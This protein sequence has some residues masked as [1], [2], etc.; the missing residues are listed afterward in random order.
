MSKNLVA[1]RVKQSWLKR[2]QSGNFND[3]DGPRSG[4]PIIAKVNEIIEKLSIAGTLAIAQHTV[5]VWGG[6]AQTS[7]TEEEIFSVT[8]PPKMD[9]RMRSSNERAKLR[10]HSSQNQF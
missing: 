8:D 10:K 5:C 1:V 6:G 9:L 7:M 3:K 4:R 2:V